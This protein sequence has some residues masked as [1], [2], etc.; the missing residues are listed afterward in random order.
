[1]ARANHA[2]AMSFDM[3]MCVAKR[4]GE[5]LSISGVHGKSEADVLFSNCSPGDN[6]F[7]LEMESSC[8][9]LLINIQ[10]G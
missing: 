4:L 7:F 5:T 1:M 2:R 8:K 6:L 10:I 3:H 9:F